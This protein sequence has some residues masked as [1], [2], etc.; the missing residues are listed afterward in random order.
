MDTFPIMDLPPEV[1]INVLDKVGGQRELLDPVMTNLRLVNRHFNRIISNPRN[2]RGLESTRM[3]V[4]QITIAQIGRSFVIRVVVKGKDIIHAFPDAACFHLRRRKG[5]QIDDG[6]IKLMERHK[7]ISCE[8]PQDFFDTLSS[9]LDKYSTDYLHFANI[10]LTRSFL[11]SLISILRRHSRI[12]SVDFEECGSEKGGE[13]EFAK[14]VDDEIFGELSSHFT[15]LEN[16]PSRFVTSKFLERFT[17]DSSSNLEL[18]FIPVRGEVPPI[19]VRCFSSIFFF[20]SFRFS[21]TVSEIIDAAE[22]RIRRGLIKRWILSLTDEESEIRSFVNK[23]ARILNYQVGENA[24]RRRFKLFKVFNL[25][26]ESSEVHVAIRWE[27]RRHRR[28][29]IAEV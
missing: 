24:A 6:W 26:G 1:L 10:L 21:T 11:S 15:A 4:A 16:V 28:G 22:G 13:T 8:A 12:P 29:F 5:Y 27:E 3:R 2:V 9:V 18:R 23:C 19:S 7:D 17:V 14:D 20:N 25:N